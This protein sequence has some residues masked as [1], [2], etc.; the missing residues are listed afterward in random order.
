MKV[1]RQHCFRQCLSCRPHLGVRLGGQALLLQSCPS[2]I[3]DLS[4][5]NCNLIENY[6][7]RAGFV[8]LISL[9]PRESSQD[10]D[11]RREKTEYKGQFRTCHWTPTSR[12]GGSPR[13]PDHS[14]HEEPNRSLGKCVCAKMG[15]RL[16]HLTASA[17]YYY[18]GSGPVWHVQMSTPHYE[19]ACSY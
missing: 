15:D 19:S 9:I 16:I 8:D 17:T 1:C 12:V 6:L 3:V 7:A 10:G 13:S 11:G 4:C 14:G 2:K 18:R 5:K